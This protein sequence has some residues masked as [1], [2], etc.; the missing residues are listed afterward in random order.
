M[1]VFQCIEW[2]FISLSYWKSIF[3]HICWHVCVHIVRLW[4]VICSKSKCFFSC[5]FC[6]RF[7]HVEFVTQNLSYYYFVSIHNFSVFSIAKTLI[8]SQNINLLN[9]YL[10][11]CS[12]WS[13]EI[14]IVFCLTQS[15]PSKSRLCPS[16]TFQRDIEL[17]VNNS[18]NISRKS[19][20]GFFNI[21]RNL[22]LMR[23]VIFKLIMIAALLHK[24]VL[25]GQGETKG[26]Y[27]GSSKDKYI[28]IPTSIHMAA[29]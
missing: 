17:F 18:F 11:S 7:C 14:F 28:P 9:F 2:R 19:A 22:R 1:G 16:K 26:S 23:C 6:P 8:F 5:R 29:R 10:S 21:T 27:C 4:A 15:M 13:S 25:Y 3:N 20:V 12:H 24:S